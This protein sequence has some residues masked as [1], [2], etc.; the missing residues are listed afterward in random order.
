VLAF[1]LEARK[2]NLRENLVRENLFHGF[3]LS[4]S[5]SL[6]RAAHVGGG[7]WRIKINTE[8]MKYNIE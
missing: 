8:Y 7:F 4:C 1:S 2:K 6:N 5:S 3:A